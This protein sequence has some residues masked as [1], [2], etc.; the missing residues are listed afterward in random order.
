MI[1]ANRSKFLYRDEFPNARA[2]HGFSLVTVAA[3]GSVTMLWLFAIS[4][5]VLPT[6]QK[7]SQTQYVTVVRSSAE[8]GLDFTVNELSKALALNQTSPLDATALGGSPKETLLPVSAVGNSFAAV[9][10]KVYNRTPPATSSIFDPQLVGAVNRWRIVEATAEYA[11]FKKTIRVILQPQIST[12][13]APGQQSNPYFPYSMFGDSYI[14]MSGNAKTDGYD[15]ALAYALSVD[16]RGGDVGTNGARASSSTPWA[17]LSGNASVGGDLHVR[18]Q[19]PSTNASVPVASIDGN[20]IVN[21]EVLLN[22]HGSGGFDGDGSGGNDNVLGA[23]PRPPAAPYDPL[24]PYDAFQP[25][26]STG[27]S[28]PKSDF[29]AAPTAPSTAYDVGVISISGNGNIIIDPTAAPPTGSVVVSGNNTKR[30]PPGD[31]RVSKFT[32]S[33]GGKIEILP[34]VTTPIRI[35][36]EGNVSGSDAISISGNGVVNGTNIPSMLQ[37]WYNGSKNVKLSGNGNLHG[38][39]YAPNS[40]VRVSGNGS[41]F[42]AITAN[43]VNNSGNGWIHYDKALGDVTRNPALRFSGGPT[44]NFNMLKTISWQEL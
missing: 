19:P 25:Y 11:G 21:N 22:G 30:I 20:A 17:T 15:S 23:V 31:Y 5:A 6:Y 27:Q 41:Y 9:N 24:L 1:R 29:P 10:V 42:G 28:L 14:T 13:Q 32:T 40:T 12:G 35:F 38:V 37:F 34:G 3:L 39:V 18:R 26:P 8:A 33:G 7:S 16:P 43:A 36:V 2:G 4:A 44:A